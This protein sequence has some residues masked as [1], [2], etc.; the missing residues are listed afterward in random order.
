MTAISYS[1][2]LSERSQLGSFT[3]GLMA[4]CLLCVSSIVTAFFPFSL[5]PITLQVHLVLFL[6]IALGR[7]LAFYAI[8]SFLFLAAMGCPVLAGG[9]GGILC[10]IGPTAGYLLF[11]LISPFIV[12]AIYERMKNSSLRL[13]AF[14]TLLIA[15]FICYSFGVSWLSTFIGFKMAFLTGVIPF[16]IGD[17]MKSLFFARCMPE[18]R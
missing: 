8:A 11:Y 15:N 4:V 5:I 18:N 9:R 6:P 1:H 17:V 14:F 13:R 12:S 3:V 16:V 7:R 10:F 2:H